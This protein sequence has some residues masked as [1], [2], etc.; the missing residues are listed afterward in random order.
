MFTS[1]PT[2]NSVTIRLVPPKLMNG[3]AIE[4]QMNKIESIYN[5]MTKEERKNPDKVESHR[6]R[7]IAAGS[8]TQPPDVA[9]TP[10]A[11]IAF[12]AVVIFIAEHP[13]H[14]LVYITYRKM[15]GVRHVQHAA[16]GAAR[17]ARAGRALGSGYEWPFKYFAAV[18]FWN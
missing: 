3:S 18:C 16:E 14:L 4:G 1:T 13:E 9:Q 17:Q 6:R 8:G 2:M 7:R 15:V 10:D 5:S 11:E 12:A